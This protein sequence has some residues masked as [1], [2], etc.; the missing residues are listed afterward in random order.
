VT[1][2]NLRDPVGL[3]AR[4]PELAALAERSPALRQAIERGR[5]LDAYRALF[6]AH[7]RRRLAEL[8]DVAATLLAHR[9]LFLKPLTSAPKMFT[10]NG[11]GTS[12]YGRADVDSNDQT[13]IATL[14]FVFVFIPVFPIGSYLVRDGQTKRKSWSF[15]AKAPL[16]T[17]MH[18]WQR[19]VAAGLLVLLAV[20]VAQAFEGYRHNTLYVVN[21]L[22]RPVTAE[23]AGL[24]K[25]TILPGEHAAFRSLVGKHVL[26][27]RDGDRIVES[28]TVDVERGSDALLWN[29]VGAAPI[30]LAHETYTTAGSSDAD[31]KEPELFCGETLIAR[32]K[33]DYVLT[34]PPK[35]ISMPKD[36]R[37]VVKTVL[38]VVPGG[39][40]ACIHY[41][42]SHGDLAKGARL[43]LEVARAT[44]AP[45]KE[46]GDS[47][48]MAM[49]V[50]PL[51]VTEPFAKEVLAREDSLEAHRLYQGVLLRSHQ[52]DRA[53]REYDARLAA[54]PGA[55]AEYL[56]LRVRTNDEEHKTID[57]VVARYPDHAFLRR[58]Q[59]FVHYG[60]FEMP[61]TVVAC[62]ALAKLDRELWLET[63]AYCVDAFV[64]VGRGSDALAFLRELIPDSSLPES[65]KHEVELLAYRVGHRIGVDAPLPGPAKGEDDDGFGAAYARAETGLPLAPESIGKLKSETVREALRIVTD[66]RTD[67]DAA[68]RRVAKAA[69]E[70]LRRV[71]SV[72]TALL[73]AEAT[74][75]D[76]MRDV[77]ERLTTNGLGDAVWTPMARFVRTGEKSDELDD[78]SLELRAAVELARSRM[79]GL[80]AN[81]KAA[82][83]A[84]A[85]ASDVLQGPVSV[86][87]AGWTP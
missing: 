69:P 1:S 36:S 59:M 3:L 37:A 72:V 13:Y 85:K 19:A 24:P 61:Q 22:S 47:L 11:F 23:L 28:A 87:I 14:F 49:D 8:G 17:L 82:L 73:F 45:V 58:A 40:D 15:L 4:A 78:L 43:A 10:I 2:T 53:I 31:E 27:I 74:R 38:G 79:A 20:A 80:S 70:A 67:P 48:P 18:L 62:E 81:E 86:A 21:G 26:T 35:T 71:P 7:R 75:R 66:A 16:A 77:A 46:L 42:L 56:A 63:V 5:P 64:A 54:K 83:F 29:V 68:L 76:D 50:L 84:Q 51:A 9:R 65:T 25:A 44:Q 30:F 6:W 41:L 60:H 52:R 57:A 32:K 12:L 33:V 39:A 55:D 34:T